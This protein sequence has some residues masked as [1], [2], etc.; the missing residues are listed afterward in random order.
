MMPPPDV[1]RLRAETPGCAHRIHF[2]NAGAGLMPTPVLMAMVEHLELEARIGGYE[3]ADARGDAVA[4]FYD[5]T[6]ELLG[7]AARTSPSRPTPPTRSRGLSPRSPS[8][9]ATR[10]SRPKTTTSRTRSHSCPFASDSVWRSPGCRPCRRAVPTPTERLDSW[11]SPAAPGRGH[12]RPDELRAGP[13]GRR[14]RP[15]LPCAGSGLPRRRLPIGRPVSL[16]VEAI[17]CD[18][19]IRDVP[20]VPSRTARDRRPLRLRPRPAAGYEPLFVD[21]RGARWIEPA[22]TRRWR[23]RPDSRTGSSR[24]PQYRLRRLRPLRPRRGLDWISPRTSA[25]AADLRARLDQLPGVRVLD[26][27]RARPRSSPSRSRAGSTPVAARWT[28]RGSTRR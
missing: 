9:P 6:G 23:R 19:L 27:G 21:M 22:Y 3:A 10:S 18:F 17:G 8:S 16:D 26:E 5:A 4:D 11:T 7:C 24:T 12:A 28:N 14:D 20:Q 13:A 2:N 1:D 25:L 15:P